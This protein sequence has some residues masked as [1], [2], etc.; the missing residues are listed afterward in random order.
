[1]P[2]AER[3]EDCDYSTIPALEIGDGGK[4]DS[5]DVAAGTI[6]QRFRRPR[7]YHLG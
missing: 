1:L 2:L 5:F 4:I 3:R 7:L 6:V